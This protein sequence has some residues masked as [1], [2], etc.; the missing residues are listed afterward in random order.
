MPAPSLSRRLRRGLAAALLAALLA[1]GAPGGGGAQDASEAL[2][3]RIADFLD[4]R[5]ELMRLDPAPGLAAGPRVEVPP[6]VLEGIR[7][8]FEERLALG[9]HGLV[10]DA[11]GRE[12]RLGVEEAFEIQSRMV[13][14][15]A[16]EARAE[17]ERAERIAGPIE[18]VLAEI[19]GALAEEPR[20]GD[21]VA[22]RDLKLR[23][24]AQLLPDGR[25]SAYLWRADHLR[26]VIAEE[27]AI[28][29]RFRG[30][31]ERLRDILIELAQG[32]DYMRACRAA[33]VPVPP[34]FVMGASDWRLQGSLGQN[35]LDPGGTAQVWTWAPPRGRGGCVAL[36]R[37]SGVAGIIC[38]GA[39]S[40]RACIW[41]NRRR[42]TGEIIPWQ[43]EPLRLRA[44]QDATELAQNCTGCHRG[45]NAF[46]VAPDDPTWC[47][48]L[49]GGRPGAGC[50]PVS[51]PNAANFTLQVEAAVNALPS[52]GAVHPRY[53]PM[54]G[55]P[56]RPGWG[57]P[58]SVDASCGGAC[59]LSGTGLA[60]SMPPACGTSCN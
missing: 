24:R 54:T 59:H 14:A 6:D 31:R 18:E 58:A 56:P 17:D 12:V 34:D 45:N 16:G 1:P 55:T 22:L 40:G 32:T 39:A 27:V 19:D 57:N 33:G 49:R 11:A 10:F 38:Q 36:P 23:A 9:G 48:L 44:M 8:P 25:R 3:D 30:L 15:I 37:G 4:A 60:V 35:I 29:E 46:L 2:A 41:D 52:A 51:G 21:L 5:P 20:E 26:G 7:F 28:D 42:G 13:E 47:R 53:V 50:A 43:A